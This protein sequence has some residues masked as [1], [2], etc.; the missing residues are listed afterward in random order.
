MYVSTP[1][2][3]RVYLGRTCRCYRAYSCVF[4]LQNDRGGDTAD[5]W[6]LLGHSRDDILWLAF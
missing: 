1:T 4:V 5:E 3:E 6:L 2:R